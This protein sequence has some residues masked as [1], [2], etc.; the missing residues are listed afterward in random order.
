MSTKTK[1]SV[2]K[3][4]LNLASVSFNDAAKMNAA[5]KKDIANWLRRVG[6]ALMKE[7]SSYAPKFVS[8]YMENQEK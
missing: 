4:S 1:K 7:G 3:K 2:E 6:T 8:R 5:T